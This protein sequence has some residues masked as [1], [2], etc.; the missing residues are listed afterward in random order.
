MESSSTMPLPTYST[1]VSEAQEGETAVFRHRDCADLLLESAPG[2]FQTVF[3]ANEDSFARNGNRPCLGV[4]TSPTGPYT[5][6]TYSEVRE[7][8]IA[9]GS[10]LY[11]LIP[12]I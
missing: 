1:F 4:R 6:K 10:G 9:V 5:W 2:G 11:D 8:A 7:L 12:E 3:D